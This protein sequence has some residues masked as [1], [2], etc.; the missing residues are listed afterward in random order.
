MITLK[1]LLSG[2]KFDELPKEHQDNINKLLEKINLVRTAYGKPMTVTSGYRSMKHHL[3]IY[4][5]KGITDKT[6]IPMKSKHLYGLAVDIS[7]PNQDLHQWCKNNVN[8][9]KKIGIWMESFSATP[10]WTHM[11]IVPYGSY[12]E[13]SSLWFNP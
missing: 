6:K 2:N 4:A 9:L 3:E 11:Q 1:E 8:E 5:A 13:G 7:T 10:N 12:K